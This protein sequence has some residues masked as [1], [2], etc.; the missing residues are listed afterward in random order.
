[1]EGRRLE[2]VDAASP[3]SPVALLDDVFIAQ[4][5]PAANRPA[6][7][8]AGEGTRARGETGRQSVVAKRGAAEGPRG[9]RKSNPARR[10]TTVCLKHFESVAMLHHMTSS[11]GHRATRC[12]YRETSSVVHGY[13]SPSS[14][15]LTET[16]G[17]SLSTGHVEKNS[18]R[19]IGKA[20]QSILAICLRSFDASTCS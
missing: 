19:D 15:T 1:M 11:G 8:R 17:T 18:W 5:P 3:T 14:R 20:N 13:E 12:V 9:C 2:R 10:Y 16:P 4:I 7:G 6:S